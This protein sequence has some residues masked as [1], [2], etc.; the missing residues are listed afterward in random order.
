MY[1]SGHTDVI[2]TKTDGDIMNHEQLTPSQKIK[3]IRMATN[4]IQEDLAAGLGC[5][6]S[7]ISKIESEDRDYSDEDIAAAKKFLGVEKAPFT[8]KEAKAFKQQLYRWRDLIKNRLTDEAR[9]KQEDLKVITKLP[10]EPDLNMLY[11]MFEIKLTLTEALV[12][13]TNVALAEEMLLSESLLIEEATDENIHH[14]HYNMGTLH[15]YKSDFKTALKYYLKACEYEADVL[16]KDISLNV[17]LAICYSMLG[18]YALAISMFEEAYPHFDYNRNSSIRTY[19]DSS[20]AIN[21]IRIGQVS[22][23]KRLLDKCLLEAPGGDGKFFL[24]ASYHNYGCACWKSKD[25][26]EAISYFDRAD[27]YFGKGDKFYIENV[28]WKIRCLI[29][30]RKGSKAKLLLSEVKPYI[31]EDRHHL[32]IFESLSHLLSIN[33]DASIDFIE[34]KTIPYLVEKYEYY[35]AIDYCEVLKSKFTKWSNK[36]YKR[37]LLDLT[38]II[39]KITDE[40]T[41]GEEMI[42]NEENICGHCPGSGHDD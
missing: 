26:E 21:Y 17:N 28:Y 6:K 8:K 29:N 38:V 40:I 19:I 41:F 16:E 5:T 7:K 33:D 24:S 3:A 20:L 2:L 30:L 36:G 23:A 32:L 11:R 37:R 13:K 42:F 31:E 35:R 39:C 22:R 34:K 9:K 25:Y 15:I 12:V 14:F 10:F 27:E 18:K 4:C 1:T